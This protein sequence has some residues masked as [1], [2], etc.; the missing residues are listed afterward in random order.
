VVDAD[1][2]V[3]RQVH[4][5]LQAVDTKRQAV[6][7][8]RQCVF[9]GERAPAPVCEDERA[10]RRKERMRHQASVSVLAE[11]TMQSMRDR[12]ARAVPA[13]GRLE[14]RSR[15]DVARQFG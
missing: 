1:D 5:E 4:V 14:E 13:T 6:V 8:R 7:E 3:A 11:P 10:R 9:R 12:P 2:A 15:H